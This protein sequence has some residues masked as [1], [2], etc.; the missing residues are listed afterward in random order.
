MHPH[1][2]EV[3][4]LLDESRSALRSAVASVPA[5]ARGRKPAADRWSV[6]EVLEH[7]ALTEARFAAQVAG[8]IDQ[9]RAAGLGPEHEPRVPLDDVIRR[10]LVDRTE[11][12]QAPEAAL[13][14]GTLDEQAAWE[15]LGRAHDRFRRALIDAEGLALG[16]VYA[17]HRRWG[18]LTP[19]Q[20]A[21]VLAG[22]AKRHAEQIAELAGQST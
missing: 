11:R 2:A 9:A 12:R 15:A 17:E 14:T 5:D 13:P 19:Y 22:H 4:V 1:L 18:A 3:F 6:N 10:R 8:A 7:L 16:T 20:W 21:E